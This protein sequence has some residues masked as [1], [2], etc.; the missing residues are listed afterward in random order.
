MGENHSG[1]CAKKK[2]KWATPKCLEDYQILDKVGS[3]ADGTVYKGIRKGIHKPKGNFVAIKSLRIQKHTDKTEITILNSL[4]HRHVI[5]LLDVKSKG[6]NFFLVMDFAA[7]GDLLTRMQRHGPIAE[8]DAAAIMQQ[9][10][11]AVAHIHKH[12]IIHRDIKPANILLDSRDDTC[13]KLADFGTAIKAEHVVGCVGTLAYMAPEVSNRRYSKAADLW[14][15][16]VVLHC[17]L[18][19]NFPFSIHSTEDLMAIQKCGSTEVFDSP[20]KRDGVSPKAQ[21][22]VRQ[23]LDV[24]PNTRITVEEALLHTAHLE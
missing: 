11:Q 6:D 24:D 22:L 17:L 12:G 19:G 1:P 14:S 4:K 23:L 3:G 8:A 21:T 13:I 2:I 18:H 5:R 15:V 9:L 20:T 10:L 7:G 16:G